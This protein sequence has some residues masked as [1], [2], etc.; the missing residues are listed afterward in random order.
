MFTMDNTEG[1]STA[2]LEALNADLR[3]RLAVAEAAGMPDALRAD[4]RKNIAEQVLA[5]F[6]A[7]HPR[8]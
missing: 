4:M 7:A 6:N 5:D 2:D 3:T 8:P 1:Y